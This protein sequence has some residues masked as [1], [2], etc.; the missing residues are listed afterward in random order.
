M[1]VQLSAQD[2]CTATKGTLTWGRPDTVFTSVCIDSRQVTPH[3]LFVPLPGVRTNGHAHISAAIEHGAAGFLFSKNLRIA[4]PNGAVGISVDDPLTAL[5]DLATWYR[6]QLPATVIGIAGSNGKTTTKEFMAQVFTDQRPTLATQGNLNNHIGLPLTVLRASPEDVFL[7][8]EMGTSRPGE[9]ATLCR[10]AQPHIGVITTIA[11]EHTE[12]LKDLDGVLAAETELIA[13]LPAVGIAIV[14]GDDPALLTA[15]RR[16]THSRIVTFGE[17][18]NNHFRA[19]NIQVTRQGTSF[20]LCTCGQPRPVQLRLIGSHFVL[21]ALATIAAA[22]E[23]GL[24]LDTACTVLQA[25]HGAPH[26]LAVVEVPA[27]QL[28]VLDDFYNAN[29][30]SMY[31]AILTAHTIRAA[32]ERLIFVLGDMLELGDISQQ[33]HQEIGAYVAKLTPPPDAVVTIGQYAQ[34]LAECAAQA[35]IPVHVFPDA[36]AATPMVLSLVLQTE[37]PQLML[38]KG[39]RGVHLEQ[40]VE[41]LVEQ[42]PRHKQA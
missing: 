31:H 19:S 32:D 37:S 35:N 30:A 27:H 40:I 28:T 13:A 22:V 36:Q 17:N 25:A 7:I 33:R 8:L 41:S 3:T 20:Q 6:Q 21:A 29:P 14:N 23:T 16:R 1:G 11:E 9:L 39:S 26:R 42:P 24:D 15:V 34:P 4:P 2:I 5:Q 10:F 38:V 18:A 12:T